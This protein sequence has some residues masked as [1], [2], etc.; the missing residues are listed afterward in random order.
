VALSRENAPEASLGAL[1]L[2]FLEIALSSFGGALAWARIVLVDR[3]RWMNDREFAETLGICQVLPGGNVINIAICVGIRS[4]GVLG[5]V[6]AVTG[7]LLV[8]LLI[9]ILLGVLYTHGAQFEPVRAGLRG[10]AAVTVGFLLGTGLKLALPYRHQ[11]SALVM[12]SLAF[13]AVGVLR[14]PLI[15]VLLVLGP[16]SIALAWRRLR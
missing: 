4:Q 1:F 5:G 3:R 8:P 13:V 15:P 9:I 2:A 10:A 16:C 7:L 12:A 14:L 6:A 11:P